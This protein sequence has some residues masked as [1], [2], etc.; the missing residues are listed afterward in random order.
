M[1][2]TKLSRSLTRCGFIAVGDNDLV[3]FFQQKAS[4]LATHFP[5]PDYGYTHKDL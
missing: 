4:Q 2:G 1:R 3:A 5:R